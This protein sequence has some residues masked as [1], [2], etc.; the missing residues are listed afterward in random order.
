[1]KFKES[2][3]DVA[4]A[5]CEALRKQGAEGILVGGAVVTIYS[6]NEYQS[7]DLDFVVRGKDKAI[8]DAMAAIGFR[9]GKGRHFER[10][11]TPYIVEVLPPPPGIGN[12]IALKF[13]RKRTRRG[14]LTL[15]DPTQCVMDRLAA[16][17]HWKDRQS[18]DQ[19]VMVAKRHR[20]RIGEVEAWSRG[21]GH[22]QGFAAF[23]EA[24]REAKRA[25]R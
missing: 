13:A 24:L 4:G 17:F 10:K 6:R 5:V 23:Q 9:K 16:F 19:A 7:F 22:P 11:G 8:L 12:A 2:I 25:E 14:M 3:A 21:E 15:Y 1:M 18:L 20:I